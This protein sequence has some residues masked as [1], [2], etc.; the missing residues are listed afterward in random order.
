[1]F[2]FS[3]KSI[4][5]TGGAGFIGSHLVET[6]VGYNAEVTVV[7]NLFTGS[8]G[9]L[10]SVKDKISLVVGDLGDLLRWQRFS[11][12][13]YDYVFHLAANPYI[14]PS[15]ENPIYDFQQNLQNT[16]FLL[17]ALRP[18]PSPPCLVN[19]SS[20]A[21]YGNPDRFPI[22]EDDITMPIS[23]YGVSKLAAERYV[24]VYCQL[25][26]LRATS[27]RLFSV[28]G[29][30]Q[31][32]QVVYDFLCK[33]RQSPNKLEI[34]GDGSQERDFVFVQDVIQAILVAATSAPNCGEAYNVAS[35]STIT[36]AQ[37]A[38]KICS[39]CNLSPEIIYTGSIRP[40]DAERWKV[41]ISNIQQI[42]YAPT[43]KISEGLAEIRDWFNQS[44]L[45]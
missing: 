18:L 41:D 16:L 29:P 20:A 2:D 6:L 30:R 7:D 26:G 33:L 15:V 14:P 24:A 10:Q 43:V 11:F 19:I 27:L 42:G 5:V 40:G 44:Q 38:A 1:M 8:L 28:Y 3:K 23:P 17:E 12:E 39:V 21:V 25:Y 13:K 31:Q 34:L 4:F 9:N 35:G 22:Q 37:L 32:K 45:N 36:I